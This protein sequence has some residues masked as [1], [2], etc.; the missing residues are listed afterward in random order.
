MSKKRALGRGLS[1][2]LENAETDITTGTPTENATRVLG[3]VAMIPV[4]QIEANPF[5]PR[6]IFDQDSLMELVQSIRELGIIQPVTVRKVGYEKFQLI[7]GERRFRASQIAGLTEI[8]AYIRVANDQGMLEMA[9][10]ENIQ[11]KNLDPIEVAISFQRLLEECHLTQEGLSER[12]GKNRATIA[13]YIRLLKLPAEI[14]A[15]LRRNEITMGHARALLSIENERDMLL[16]FAKIKSEGWSVRQIEQAGQELKQK[17]NT[18]RRP[19]PLPL[20]FEHQKIKSDLTDWFGTK[21]ELKRDDKGSGKI[22]I[23]FRTEDELR[24][25]IEKLDL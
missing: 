12:I 25:I 16:A 23:N 14:Q 6:S 8:P 20:S 11:R 9:I 19:T 7:S 13:N 22:E 10:V 5:Q 24:R 4:S 2:L 21:V 15:A 1:A 18:T 17:E 3:S